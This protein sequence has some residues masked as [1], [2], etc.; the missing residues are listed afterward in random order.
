[1][2]HDHDEGAGCSKKHEHHES[3][4]DK[5]PTN[6]ALNPD[7]DGKMETT[8]RIAG[9]DCADEV[10]AL[11]Q[12]LRPLKGVREVRV[13]LVGGKVTLL[14]DES[15][16]PELLIRTIAPTGLKA[17]RDGGGA[18]DTDVEEAK[19]A[20]QISVAVSGAFTGLGLLIEWTKFSMV[21][22]KSGKL[23]EVPSR[24][25]AARTAE[26]T[27]SLISEPGSRHPPSELRQP[28]PSRYCRSFSRR[29]VRARKRTLFTAGTLRSRIAP[30]SSYG[31]S[32]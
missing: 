13:N 21:A 20:R 15:V 10:E 16:T 17:S 8:L 14:H 1:M 12:V 9:M 19:R 27:R 11:E 31:M 4:A 32:S 26:A 30:I 6:I 22:S 25:L 23:W 24:A 28:Y 7:A 3:D 2:S 18:S 5:A 29:S